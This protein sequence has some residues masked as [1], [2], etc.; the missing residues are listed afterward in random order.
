MYFAPAFGAQ[1]PLYF[2]CVHCESVYARF[3]GPAVLMCLLQHGKQPQN[4]VCVNRKLRM[5]HGVHA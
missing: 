2:V 3:R 1:R 4:I 5:V